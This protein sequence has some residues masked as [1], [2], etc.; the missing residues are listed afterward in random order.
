MR[1]LKLLSTGYNE[2]ESSRI[3][4]ITLHVSSDFTCRKH[5]DRQSHSMR[6]MGGRQG[7]KD[8]RTYLFKLLTQIRSSTTI[9][10]HTVCRGRKAS[11]C[12]QRAVGVWR[13]RL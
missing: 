5:R 9:R 8:M 3:P 6:C 1:V 12:V 11:A 2:W 7:F 13:V 4:F 10:L